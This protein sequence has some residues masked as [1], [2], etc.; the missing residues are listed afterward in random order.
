MDC[1]RRPRYRCAMRRI[2]C[3]I[4]LCAAPTL[5]AADEGRII[6][7][8]PFLVDTNGNIAR[9]P[10]L[11]D[12]DAYQAYLHVHTNDVSGMRYDVQ[13]SAMENLKLR[14]EIRVTGTNNT[15]QTKTLETDV[16]AGRFE[17]WTHLKLTG[18]DYKNSGTFVAWHATLWK[19]STQLSEQ[20]SFL[21]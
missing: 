4:F 9:S 8:L 12:R 5:F 13:C 18:D 10:S 1:R 15:L 16:P 19:D 14:L 21:W 17:N 11:F 3:L 6:K 7:V 20:K 2:L